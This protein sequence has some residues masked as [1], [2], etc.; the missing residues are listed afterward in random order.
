M[1]IYKANEG[2]RKSSG[3]LAM[4]S[5]NACSTVAAEIQKT[6]T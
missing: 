1:L 2:T 5:H 6:Q 4:V 3:E